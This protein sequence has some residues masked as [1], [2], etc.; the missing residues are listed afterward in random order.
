MT[1]NLLT[2]IVTLFK[3]KTLNAI[4]V[5][6]DLY[7]LLSDGDVS[8]AINL[9]QD[10]DEEVDNAL[11]EYN[12]QTHKVKNRPN[13][14]RSGKGNDY[15][16]EKLPSTRQRYIN[17][18]E[19]FFLLGQPVQWRK[20]GGEDEAYTLFMDFL[21]ETR[22]DSMIRKAKRLAG[23]ETESAIVYHLVRESDDEGNEKIRTIQFVVSRSQGYRL[24]PLIDQYGQMSAFAYGYTLNENGTN[25]RHWDILT[26]DYRFYCKRSSK[27]GWSIETYKNTIGKI[28]AIYF[29][30]PKAWAGAEERIER[31]EDL[32]SKIADTNNYFA[33]PIASATADVINSM[34]DP[35]K[36]GKLIQLTGTQSR[37]EYVNPPTSS[38]TRRDEMISLNDSILFDTFT[39]DLS[40]EKMRG[41]GSLSGVAIKNSMVL[42][43]IKRANRAELYGEMI[44]RLK[45]VVIAILKDMHPD[46]R[47][48][49]DELKITFTFGEPF[50]EDK[51]TQWSQLGALYGAGLVSCE[52]AV[53][54][55]ALTDAPEDEIARLLMRSAEEQDMQM[56]LL[57]MKEEAKNEHGDEENPEPEPKD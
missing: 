51:T 42:G 57:K 27:V 14:Y 36:P 9:M 28:P 15:I 17:E 33:D 20:E 16:T 50:A 38:E 12:P 49:L 8:K 24:R 41:M 23:A 5:E 53:T 40:F 55:L 48:M 29:R 25:V 13:K 4:G 18:V 6:R 56:E 31:E 44:D 52:T 46:K 37:F 21:K 39:P 22:F 1:D 7:Q 3:N 34:T 2:Q 54:M 32:N 43:Y 47:K 19:L 11:S 35:Q 30:Q 10:H 26:K 45:N